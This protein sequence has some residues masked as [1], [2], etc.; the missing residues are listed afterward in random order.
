MEGL[1]RK[2]RPL[3]QPE[4][5]AEAQRLFTQKQEVRRTMTKMEPPVKGNG[6][7]SSY[8]KNRAVGLFEGEKRIFVVLNMLDDTVVSHYY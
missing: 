1:P 5:D 8:K 3:L 2:R 6:I 4:Y 7:F